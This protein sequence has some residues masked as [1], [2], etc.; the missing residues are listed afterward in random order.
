MQD[1]LLLAQERQQLPGLPEIEG[2]F[3]DSRQVVWLAP[4]RLPVAKRGLVVGPP[5]ASNRAA[6]E[7]QTSARRPPL[8]RPPRANRSR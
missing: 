2:A 6:V 1:L 7:R 5:A 4:C 8:Q 3:G